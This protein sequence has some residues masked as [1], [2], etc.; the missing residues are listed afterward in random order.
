M[1]Y[2]A[3]TLKMSGAP[4]NAGVCDARECAQK[5]REEG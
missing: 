1:W 5:L 2:F 4:R 3:W